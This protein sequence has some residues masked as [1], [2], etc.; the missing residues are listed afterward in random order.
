MADID[1]LYSLPLDDFTSKRDALASELRDAGKKEDAAEVKRLRKPSLAAWAVNQLAREKPDAM[2]ELFELRE[3]IENSS[4][5]ADMRAASEERRRL[6]AELVDRAGSILTEAGRAT[7]ANTMQAITQTLHAGDNENER[8]ALVHG[9]LSR[10]LTPSG[11]GG[12][13]ATFESA[14]DDADD[15]GDSRMEEKRRR[16]EE[17]AEEA[18][19]AEAE[20]ARLSDELAAA[21][22]ALQRAQARSDMA[23]RSAEEARKN[24]ER[25]KSELGD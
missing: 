24:A 7:G 15:A 25:A 5:A 4:S 9:R 12:F 14:A 10:E 18:E 2:K 23:R 21:E 11:F 22:R 3:R 6:I 20:A 8:D 16:S 1:D 13:S 19:A 17:L